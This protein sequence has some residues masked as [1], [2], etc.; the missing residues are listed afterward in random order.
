MTNLHVTSVRDRQDRVLFVQI[1][2]Q[3]ADELYIHIVKR[4]SCSAV[5]QDILQELFLQFWTR[6]TAWPEGEE[7]RK[8]LFGAARYKVIDHYAELKQRAQFSSQVKQHMSN[9]SQ[10]LNNVH[11]TY[12]H[13]EALIEQELDAMAK[14]MRMVF[15]MRSNNYSNA[16]IAELLNLSEQTVKNNYNQAKQRI[17][18]CLSDQDLQNNRYYTLLFPH[19][20]LIHWMMEQPSVHPGG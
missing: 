10:S 9:D 11:E 20:A 15:L 4:V 16:E 8:Y 7:L 17:Q 18:R 13:L 2:E 12:R 6:R 3:Y 14:N 1:Y 5:A 19:L